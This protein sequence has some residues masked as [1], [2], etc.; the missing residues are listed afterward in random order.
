[1]EIFFTI[2]SE[3]SDHAICNLEDSYPEI[4]VSSGMRTSV[5][6]VSTISA[7]QASLS[8]LVMTSLLTSTTPH[9][10]LMLVGGL[11]C[12]SAVINVSV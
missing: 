10:P 7:L 6:R 3:V 4:E 9:L 12:F 1:M 5:W 2:N 8:H 11:A